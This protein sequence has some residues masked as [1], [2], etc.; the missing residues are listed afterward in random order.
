MH[1]N[2]ALY[3]APLAL[4]LGCGAP[5][6]KPKPA[7][8]AAPAGAP[9]RVP[10]F[11]GLG[12]HKRKV[13][14]RS[15]EAQRYFDQ[16]LAFVYAFNHDEAI[17][18]FQQ[19]ADLDPRC[20]MAF[21]GVAYAN[22]PHINN[23]GLDE[24]HAKAAWEA[25]GK[26]RAAVAGASE[27]ERALIEALGARYAWPAPADRKALDEAYA[28]AMRAAWK[29]FPADHDVGAL[30][31]EALMDL[32]P[33]DLWT[34]DGKPQPGADEVVAT[35][36]AVLDKAPAHPLANHLYIHAVEAS[37]NPEKADAAADRLRES[38]PGLGHLVHMPSHI[39]VRA[40]RWRSA[41]VANE[42][43]IAADRRYREI[44][45]QQGF[46]RVY[47][48]H[49]RDMLA[50]AAMMEG[51]SATAID[52][53]RA[54]VAEIPTEF[55][56]ETAAFTDGLSVKPL[57]V[58]ARFGRWDEILRE[59]EPP[60][61]LPVSRAL[62]RSARGIALAAQGRIAEA[63]AE[64]KA[65][66]EARGRVAKDALFFNNTS[67]DVLGVAEHMLAGEIQ[68]QAG[69]TDE[70]LAALREAVRRED[71]L[72][73]NEPPDWIIPVR[74]ALGAALL[75][76]GRAADAEKVYVDDLAIH[77]ANGWALFGLARA[78]RIAGRTAEADEAEKRFK[79]AW[80]RSDVK[81]ESSCFCLPGS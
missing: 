8:P 50:F 71:A 74:H 45:K 4:A 16:G 7:P 29:R 64:Q 5:E 12:A 46:Y 69:K 9:A 63:E 58:L 34:Q 47:M 44:S 21:W 36:E 76:A 43:A 55:L 53:M 78:L 75:K 51:Q 26:A 19:A 67:A 1:R 35:L 81:L 11:E 37:P 3:V 54:M 56:R 77:P 15:A 31:A 57:E 65:F 40:G 61:W 32:R 23:P 59:P 38:A 42:K 6:P 18:S 62:R 49:N 24:A 60:E 27:V 17:R 68:I 48:A 13:T 30:L 80:A 10:L 72:R 2:L 39:D 41:I 73:Y 28:A 33:W 66:V 22:G 14:A 52:S 79:T 70:G 20:A 25:L